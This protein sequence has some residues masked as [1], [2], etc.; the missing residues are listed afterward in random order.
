LNEDAVL[1]WTWVCGAMS[2]RPLILGDIVDDNR[3]Q[4]RWRCDIGN[5]FHLATVFSQ[6][7]ASDR[8]LG[9]YSNHITN[10]HVDLVGKNAYLPR[11]F[12]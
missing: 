11:N 1:E 10:I 7:W 3:G 5:C 8:D 9:D 6:Y 12:W 2:D 4:H